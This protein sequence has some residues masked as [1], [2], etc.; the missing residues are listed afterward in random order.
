MR[1]YDIRNALLSKHDRTRDFTCLSV[2]MKRVISELLNRVRVRMNE[3]KADGMKKAFDQTVLSRCTRLEGKPFS[4]KPN[5]RLAALL[6]MSRDKLEE[7]KEEKAR[8]FCQLG[9]GESWA[10]K[11]SKGYTKHHTVCWLN[12]PR[13]LPPLAT[14][15]V[16]RDADVEELN[17][18]W[19]SGLVANSCKGTFFLG[20]DE[21]CYS[22]NV[23]MPSN[24]NVNKELLT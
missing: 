5:S 6:A 2:E 3:K 9:C 17:S 21:K 12:R 22:D 18:G 1:Q 16:G 15:P 24:K 7:P 4:S 20:N 13:L 8:H 14:T 19:T 10:T 23:F 11:T